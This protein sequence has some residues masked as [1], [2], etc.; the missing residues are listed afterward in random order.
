MSSVNKS[1]SAGSLH[2]NSSFQPSDNHARAKNN[3]IG[4]RS[5]DADMHRPPDVPDGIRSPQGTAALVYRHNESQGGGQGLEN[6]TSTQGGTLANASYSSNA[7]FS[8]GNSEQDEVKAMIAERERHFFQEIS[9]N[10]QLRDQHPLMHIISAQQKLEMVD[11]QSGVL[12]S[13]SS[14]KTEGHF[15]SSRYG[16]QGRDAYDKFDCYDTELPYIMGGRIVKPSEVKLQKKR[17]ALKLKQMRKQKKQQLMNEASSGIGS[18]GNGG[19]NNSN[20]SNSVGLLSPL[21][22]GSGG[23]GGTSQQ[24]VHS[25]MNSNTSITTDHSSNN[26]NNGSNSILNSSSVDNGD[27]LAMNKPATKHR[28]FLND[29][30]TKVEAQVS[31]K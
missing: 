27:V 15:G 8:L 3:A 11:K 2:R 16:K 26:P 12:A 30:L 17:A 29:A 14:N 25:G 6:D 19:G 18:T 22:A 23:G 5:S 9:R 10:P 31:Q 1:Q 21:G 13:K 4:L 28:N 7:S 20:N 24:S